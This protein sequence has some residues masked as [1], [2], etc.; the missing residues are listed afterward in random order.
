[1]T[2][3]DRPILFGPSR[4]TFFS[5]F[6]LLRLST[7]STQPL[8]AYAIKVKPPHPPFQC[9]KPVFQ[10]AEQA[11][12]WLIRDGYLPNSQKSTKGPRRT[13]LQ[14][15]HFFPKRTCSS[16]Q[17]SMAL[18]IASAPICVSREQRK[19]FCFQEE[20]FVFVCAFCFFL[21]LFL[22]N[23]KRVAHIRCSSAPGRGTLNELLSNGSRGELLLTGFSACYSFIHS[24]SYMY[25]RAH[26]PF[27]SSLQ[28]L[29]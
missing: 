3:P 21:F 14:S 12:H 23:L 17:P 11:R 28:T 22:S 19:P 18:T 1:M 16:Y 9:T 4:S 26:P 29:R 13:S 24:K 2:T 15:W 7:D 25:M 10:Y 8:P 6:P 27:S 20:T 5:Y